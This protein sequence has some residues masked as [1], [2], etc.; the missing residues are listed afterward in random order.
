MHYFNFLHQFE[1]IFNQSIS[2]SVILLVP[3]Q[4]HG[5][6]DNIENVTLQLQLVSIATKYG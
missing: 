5:G 1:K 6:H 3:V 2:G 4:I